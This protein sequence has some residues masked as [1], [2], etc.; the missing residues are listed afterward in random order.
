MS[1]GLQ[2]LSPNNNLFLTDKGPLPIFLQKATVYGSYSGSVIRWSTRVTSKKII[3]FL[4]IPI[5]TFYLNFSSYFYGPYTDSNGTYY[6]LDQQIINPT[7]QDLTDVPIEIYLFTLTM[8]GPSGDP[9]G[10]VI[11]NEANEL[12]FDSG[13]SDFLKVVDNPF[14]SNPK[15]DSNSLTIKSGITKPALLLGVM[16]TRKKVYDHYTTQGPWYQYGVW[17]NYYTA[18]WYY[19]ETTFRRSSTTEYL[20][21]QTYLDYHSYPGSWGTSYPTS[22]LGTPGDTVLFGSSLPLPIPTINGTDYD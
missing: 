6:T 15:L 4:S 1:L 13:W 14:I 20:F 5:T 2:I 16:Q 10:L 11:R 9:F 17:Q 3:P 7:G 18:Y 22:I 12:C 21:N 19:Y 8:P